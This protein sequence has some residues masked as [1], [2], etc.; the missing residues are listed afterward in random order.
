MYRQRC[1]PF[2]EGSYGTYKY[3]SATVVLDEV[4]MEF[5]EDLPGTI[6]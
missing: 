4:H 3:F 1:D 5:I 2:Y 6:S